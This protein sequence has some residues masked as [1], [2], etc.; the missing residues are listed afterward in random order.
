MNNV[1]RNYSGLPDRPLQGAPYG[2]AVVVPAV[3]GPCHRGGRGGATA[4]AA[5]CFGDGSRG[6]ARS[7]RP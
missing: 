3:A 7:L 4:T 1:L 6:I 2:L 5:R